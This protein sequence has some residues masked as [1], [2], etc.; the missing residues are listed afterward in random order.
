[1][2]TFVVRVWT[3]TDVP[4]PTGDGGAPVLRGRVEHVRSG[5]VESFHAADQ[6]LGFMRQTIGSADSGLAPRSIVVGTP[7]ATS[8]TPK[9]ATE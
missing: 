4:N 1:M 2:E 8:V 5:R 9:G 7:A 3:S 6:L